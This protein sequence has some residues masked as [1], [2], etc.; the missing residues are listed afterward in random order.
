MAITVTADIVGSRQLADRAGAQRQIDETVLRVETAMPLAA[1]PLLPTVGDE[2]QGVYPTLPSALLATLLLRLALPEGIDLRFGIGVGTVDMIAARGGA[3]PE[4]PAW[5]A[6]RAAID[7]VHDLQ[8]RRAPL[9][10]TWVV[11]AVGQDEVPMGEIRLANAYL[12][13]RDELVG[14]MSERSRRLTYGR[15]L[16]QTQAALAAEEGISQSAVSQALRTAGAAALIE[17]CR[18]LQEA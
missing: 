12:L 6:A 1:Q 13:A 11:A 17:G 8:Q 10:R 3:L 18:S 15:C 14:A 4:G 16:G 2:Q 5:W 9:S 7:H